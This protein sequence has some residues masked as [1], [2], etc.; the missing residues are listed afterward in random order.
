MMGRPRGRLLAIVAGASCVLVLAY[1][2]TGFP[3]RI[4]ERRL[5][6]RL[7]EGSEEECAEVVEALLGLGPGVFRAI[8]DCLKTGSSKQ[9]LWC[10][11][12][13][14]NGQ[15]QDL[16][17][18]DLFDDVGEAMIRCAWDGSPEVRERLV[19]GAGFVNGLPSFPGMLESSNGDVRITGYRMLGK[20]RALG[21]VSLEPLV[22][23]A[24]RA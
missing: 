5:L 18:R 13:I 22:P 21:R 11:H 24:F 4:E 16:L 1:F 6:S 12:A 19:D 15:E 17:P 14:L 8:I 10:L 20:S 3:R 9:R 23:I 7:D 2:A